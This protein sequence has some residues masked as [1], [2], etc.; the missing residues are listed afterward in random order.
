M[1][2]MDLERWALIGA[3]E[4][5]AQ[6]ATEAAA[7]YKAFPQLRTHAIGFGTRAGGTRTR[8]TLSAEGRKRISD[9]Q[10]ARWAKLKRQ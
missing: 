10:K 7:I 8:G 1:K 9:A 3:R 5:L 4:R 2:R 6:L